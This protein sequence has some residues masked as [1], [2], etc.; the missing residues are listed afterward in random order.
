MN[1]V[2]LAALAAACCAVLVIPGGRGAGGDRGRHPPRRAARPDPP[3][4]G[5]SPDGR[6]RPALVR[7]SAAL[8]A[9]AAWWLLGG[10]VGPVVGVVVLLLAPAV[11]ARLEPGSVRRRREQM[12]RSAPVVADVMAAALAAG[13]PVER[14]LPAIARA[15]GGP[16][17]LALD[18]VDRRLAV[19]H[20]LA[21]AWSPLLDEPGLGGIAR[22][23]VR[24]GRTGAPLSDV[25]EAT[26]EEL[27]SAA[28]AAGMARIRSAA[29][30]CVLPLGLC[31]LPAFVLLGIAP[32]VGGLLPTF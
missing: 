20:C 16:T 27:R 9:V 2:V 11:V 15:V 8:A 18:Q 7:L 1:L 30:R 23:V 4:G 24:S 31:L 3:S 29:V 28:R 19:G 14:A 13:T 12:V 32:I 21:Q 5:H 10:R 25:L 22:C 17:G 26:A 6:P